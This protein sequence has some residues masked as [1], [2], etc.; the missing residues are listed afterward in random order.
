MRLFVL[1]LAMPVY[2][3]TDIRTVAGS[4]NCAVSLLVWDEVKVVL[5]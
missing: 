3:R 5:T 2:P 4:G 1:A